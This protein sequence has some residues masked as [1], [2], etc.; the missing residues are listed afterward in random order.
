MNKIPKRKCLVHAAYFLLLAVQSQMLFS[1]SKYTVLLPEIDKAIPADNDKDL[2][3]AANEIGIET[4]KSFFKFDFKNLPVHAKI[5]FL[6]LKIYNRPNDITSGFTVQTITI[7][8]GDN[9]WTGNE[10]KLDDPLLDWADIE[11]NE[12]TIGLAEVKKSTES[13]AAE[14]KIPGSFK[15]IPDFLKDSILSLAARSPENRQDTKFFS[16]I[17]SETSSNFSKKPKLIV[18]YEIDSYPFRED[19][20]QP[21]VNSQHNSLLGWKSNTFITSAQVR[22]LPNAQNENIQEAGSGGGILI[23]KNQPVIFT[24]A[25]AGTTSV[26]YVK[27]LNSKG[28]VLWSAGV[29]DVASCSPLIDEKGR[30]YYISKSGKLTILELN[31]KGNNLFSIS[32]SGIYGQIGNV[33]N[34]VTLGYDKTLY[35][36][37][38]K[39]IFAVSAYPQLKVR[40]KYEQ[41][42]N[43]INGPVSLSKDESKAFFINI[44]KNQRRGRL[45]VLDN[46]DGSLIAASDYVLGGYTNDSNYYIPPPVVQNNSRVFVLD[47]FDNSSTLFVFDINSKREITTQNI[48]SGSNINTGISQPVIDSQSNVFFVY[49]NSLAKYDASAN[50]AIVFN[51][52]STLDNA[53][54]LVAD[55][56]SNIYAADPYSSP[57][58]IMGFKNDTAAPNSFSVAMDVAIGNPRKN[59]VLAPDGTLYT[60]TATNLISTTPVRFDAGTITIDSSNLNTNTLYRASDAIIV[61]GFSI[62]PSVNTILH[63]GGGVSFKAGFSVAKGA[64]LN[65]KTGF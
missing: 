2:R 60:T 30:L 50:K 25:A 44:D 41:K 16:S 4:V 9:D 38:D 19:W 18:T 63:S 62:L 39:G 1:Q 5:G 52:S 23:Y 46:L 49:N 33:N 59:L 31:N 3:I 47:G 14:L 26:F 29:D 61:E 11:K 27:Q 55:N 45:V 65:C 20:A 35:L 53:S 57:K 40:W 28:D 7:L 58:K 56:S 21:F 32:L 12:E 51:G 24:Q 15:F 54:I 42:T 10:S 34:T 22:K 43:E 36:P 37:S 48:S 8:K 17:T 13:V 6:D 64:Q